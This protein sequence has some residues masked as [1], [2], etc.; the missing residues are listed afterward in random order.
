[1]TCLKFQI[2]RYV[3]EIWEGYTNTSQSYYTHGC[4][5]GTYTNRLL[6]ISSL[7]VVAICLSLVLAS[8]EANLIHFRRL[9]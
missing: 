9:P 1:M 4:Y 3:V 5:V 7:L 2:R 6:I 8:G